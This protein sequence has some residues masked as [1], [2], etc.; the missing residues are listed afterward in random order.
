MPATLLASV[1]IM[2]MVARLPMV[3][4]WDGLLPAWWSTLHPRY[5]T[6]SKAIA[7]V[8]IGG[9]ALSVLS[10]LGAGNQEAVQVSTGTG[11][12]AMC[13]QYTLLFGTVLFGFRAARASWGIRLAALS[14]FL[15]SAG[16]ADS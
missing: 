8:S 11:I 3:A 1:I 4:G 16:F 5:R 10:L 14:A 15:V 9:F 13:I 12:G 2:G 7:A 6:P